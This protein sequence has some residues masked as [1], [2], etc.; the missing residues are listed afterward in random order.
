[1]KILVVNL[2]T[3]VKYLV[4]AIA[5]AVLIFCTGIVGK[6][7]IGVFGS[8]KQLPIY[9]VETAGSKVAITFDCAWGA[10]DIPDI[11]KALKQENVKA[12]FFIVGQWAEKYGN[13]VKM[14]SEAG[15]DIGNHSYSHFR[16]G[17][18]DPEKSKS[19]ISQCSDVLEGITGK[20]VELFRAPYGDYNNNL[21]NAAK[22]L[23]CFTIQ[24]NVDSLDWKPDIG[25]DEIMSR[26][27]SKLV[28]GSI[29]LFHN[30]TNHTAAI[31]GD[32][33]KTIK[34]S[35]YEIVPV[36]SLIIR[37]DYT[38]DYEGRQHTVSK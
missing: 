19:E 11:L 7:A 35:G 22:S 14:I 24:W 30:D 1:M 17:V 10:D 18:L 28:S 12:T 16:M 36:S 5:A 31:L 2:R 34:S 23:G 38:I 13:E 25:K 20:K 32:I 15:H 21:I 33:I 4:I 6:S 26:I 3:V 29:L 9:S 37:E 27:K 8:E